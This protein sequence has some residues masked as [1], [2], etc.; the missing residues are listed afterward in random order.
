[1]VEEMRSNFRALPAIS[2]SNCQPRSQPQACRN[3]SNILIIVPL[4]RG[5]PTPT[6]PK[7]SGRAN[8]SQR[9]T[10]GSFIRCCTSR[11]CRMPKLD[12]AAGTEPCAVPRVEARSEFVANGFVVRRDEDDARLGEKRRT[13]Q[14]QRKDGAPEESG[15]LS[16][17]R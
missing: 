10:N 15:D 12:S 16:L 13:R 17:A 6:Q 5:S 3:A 4:L 9:V 14:S 8:C 11:F 1:V 2:A 7:S